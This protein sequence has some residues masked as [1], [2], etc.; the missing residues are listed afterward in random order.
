MDWGLACGDRRLLGASMAGLG[1]GAGRGPGGVGEVRAEV[2][3]ADLAG[4]ARGAV[5]TKC[6]LPFAMV[7]SATG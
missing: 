7:G 3:M 6:N 1:I 2:E 4:G 5:S